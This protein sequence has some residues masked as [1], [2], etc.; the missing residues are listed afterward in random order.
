M[1]RLQHGRQRLQV[2]RPN[3]Y[4]RIALLEKVLDFLL[5]VFGVFLSHRVLEHLAQEILELEAGFTL[6]RLAELAG[7][8][9]RL[10]GV[11]LA[12]GVQITE[13]DGQFLNHLAIHTLEQL[14]GGGDIETR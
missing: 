9:R 12:G 2:G 8:L 14:G 1:F 13:F 7:H 3:R 5:H 10:F 4:E 6:K 11:S